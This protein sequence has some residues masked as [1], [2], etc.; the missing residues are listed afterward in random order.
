[1]LHM[2]K[3]T[4]NPKVD[5]YFAKASKWQESEIKLREIAIGCGLEEGL[6]YGKPT[7]YC[8]AGKIF[9]IHTFKNYAAMLFYKGVLMKD[10]QKILVQQ[11]EYVQAGRQLRFSSAEQITSMEATI[12]DYIQE[13]IRVEESG[14]K[15]VMKKTSEFKMVEEFANK[16]AENPALADSFYALTP[17]RQRGYL[18][19]FSKA[20][21]A[22]TREDRIG[23]SV[24]YILKGK[25]ITMSGKFEE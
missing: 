2:T 13:A 23:K 19:Y 1:M 16:L 5:W 21:Q 22:K 4:P 15:V 18:L 10:P 8:E 11:T 9:L 14:E 25:G 12:K 6:T 20:K 3:N 24:P 17:G 7:Y